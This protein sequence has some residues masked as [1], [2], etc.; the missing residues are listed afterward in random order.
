LLNAGEKACLAELREAGLPARQAL[1]RLLALL[2]DEQETHLT[3]AEVVEIA[4][5]AKLPIAPPAL[6]RHL[7]ALAQH[8]LIS[9]LPT[10]TAESVFD[11]VPEPH[12]H[13]VYEE[14]AQTVD[15]HVSPATL[16][17]II[18]HALDAAPNQVE[19]LV[20]FRARSIGAGR[21]RSAPAAS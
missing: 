9:R 15:L 6:A 11:T 10:A 18:R 20:R 7:E 21:N 2:R 8:R 17:A 12:A 4:G 1:A 16:L 19:V 3:L 14:P 5:K 13:L